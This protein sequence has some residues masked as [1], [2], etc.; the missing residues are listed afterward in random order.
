MN[1]IKNNFINR[2]LSWLDF[3][4]RVL[5]EAIRNDNPIMERLRFLGI[6]SSN[7]DEFFMVRVAEIKRCVLSGI[8]ECDETGYTP[9]EL[10]NTLEK[11]LHRFSAEQY[12]CLNSQ[13]LPKL[14]ECGFLFL[15]PSQMNKKQ[16]RFIIGYY[17]SVVFPVLTPIAADNGRIFPHILGKSLHIAVRL[18]KK[19]EEICE[20]AI[21]RVPPNI[22][23]FLELPKSNGMRSFAILEDIIIYRMGA[24]FKSHS[25]KACLPFRITRNSA[26]EIDSDSP[27]LVREVKKSIKKRKSGRPIRLELP[28]NADPETKAFLINNLRVQKS[29]TYTAN[30]FLDLSFLSK[31]TDFAQ[32][33]LCFKPITPVYPPADFCGADD[34]FKCIKKRDRFVYH[35][36]ESFECV[37][38]FINAAA[39]DA[40]VLALKQTLY[41]VSGNSPIIDALIRAAKNGKQVTVL[42]ELKARFDEENNLEW[43]KK[44]EAAGCHVIRGIPGVKT[45]C[46]ILSVVRREGDRLKTYVHMGTGNYNDITAN[47]YTDMGLFTCKE[48]FSRDAATLFNMLTGYAG[49]P[50]YKRFVVAPDDMRD[51]FKS[52]IKSEIE[53]ARRGLPCGIFAKINSLSD[54]EVIDLLYKASQAGVPIKLIVRGICCLIPGKQGLSE[55]IEVYSIVGQLL[56]HSRI[57]KFENGGKPTTWIGSADLM[58]RNLSHRIELIFP[59]FDKSIKN[60]IDRYINIMLSD[61]HNLRTMDSKG[62]YSHINLTDNNRPYNSHRELSQA[63][64]SAQKRAKKMTKT[65]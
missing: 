55:N 11:K 30:G 28:K 9:Q 29:E 60:R 19:G 32:P 46:K 65:D 56:E 1:E 43:A 54:I 14:E 58:K 12:K 15:K 38:D 10:L 62:E 64:L 26:I 7:L 34:I 61:T 36:Y 31:F 35:P 27:N 37:I 48:A 51:F 59:I 33:E 39:N 5:E 52:K 63:A 20:Y 47:L 50:V 57:F 2:E 22:P 41:R 24:L 44:L 6:T 18:K 45:H 21:V 40:D 23:R 25:I 16:K 3:N 42:V 4:K 13:L 49:K 17:D 8:T 53:N